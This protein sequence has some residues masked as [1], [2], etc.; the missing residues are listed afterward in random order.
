MAIHYG[1]GCAYWNTHVY[2][3]ACAKYFPD[4]FAFEIEYSPYGM[5]SGLCVGVPSTAVQDTFVSL[6]PCGASA[7]TVWVVDLANSTGHSF[8][9]TYAPLIN[10]SNTNFSHPFVLTYPQNSL[11]DRHAAAA[12]DHADAAPVSPTAPARRSA[13]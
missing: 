7:K 4:D 3:A 6:Q 2:P 1:G 11:A 12:A 10:G 13:P 9:D 8:T 5:N